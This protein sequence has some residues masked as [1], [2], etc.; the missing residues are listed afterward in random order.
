MTGFL[1]YARQHETHEKLG[2]LLW[3]GLLYL[4]GFSRYQRPRITG[5][6]FQR[7][8]REM[9]HYQPGIRIAVTG[10]RLTVVWQLATHCDGRSSA[11]GRRRLELSRGGRSALEF[12]YGF[13]KEKLLHSTIVLTMSWNRHAKIPNTCVALPRFSKGGVAAQVL[14]RI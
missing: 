12:A 7:H 14:L 11:S 3:A 13:L 1:E 6:I 2:W 9:G 4:R 5:R 10:A 8:T